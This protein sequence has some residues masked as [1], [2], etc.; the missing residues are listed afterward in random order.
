MY[1]DE[2][3]AIPLSGFIDGGPSC[4]NSKIHN[5]NFVSEPCYR[6]Q[7][8]HMKKDANVLNT[9]GLIRTRNQ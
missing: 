5:I 7:I 3:E 4:N 1:S 9:I 8:N 6:Y 2:R